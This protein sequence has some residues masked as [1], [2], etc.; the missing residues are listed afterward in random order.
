MKKKVA[1]IFLFSTAYAITRYYVFGPVAGENI[2]L[3][4]MNKAVSM[5]SVLALML[6]AFSHFKEDAAKSR[7]WGK[8]T[9]HSAFIH[10]VMSF[11]LLTPEYYPVFYG[12][13]DSPERMDRVGELVMLFGVLATY[14]YWLTAQSEGGSPAMRRFK[15][16]SCVFVGA[17]I[18][19]LGAGGWL[20]VPSYY[21]GMPPITLITAIAAGIALVFYILRPAKQK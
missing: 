13:S 16:W 15:I 6:A 11:P 21:G 14:F 5:G 20:N 19:E 10:I 1:A 9:L 8:I 7:F 4:L 18:F 3:F 12:W 2:P 17:H